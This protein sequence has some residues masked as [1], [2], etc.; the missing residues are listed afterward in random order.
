M[1]N[2]TSAT[3]E[4][5]KKIKRI[6]NIKRSQLTRLAYSKS[7]DNNSESIKEEI[8]ELERKLSR[9]G[10]KTRREKKEVNLKTIITNMPPNSILIDFLKV[11]LNSFDGKSIASPGHFLRA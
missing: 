5:T 2:Q 6:I 7:D 1:E 11:S 9:V 8:F 10:F 4:K 3:L